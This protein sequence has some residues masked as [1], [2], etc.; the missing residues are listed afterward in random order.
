MGDNTL[1]AEFGLEV[2]DGIMGIKES[3]GQLPTVDHQ[4]LWPKGES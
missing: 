3:E 1:I 2:I 4:L